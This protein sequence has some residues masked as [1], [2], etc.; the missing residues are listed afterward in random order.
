MVSDFAPAA[1]K[2]GALGSEAVIG[3]V[4]E[5]LQERPIERLVVDPVMVS[6]HGAPLLPDAA[7]RAVRDKVLEH[8]LLVTP[9]RH[10]AEALTGRSV[11]DPGSMKEA[12]QRIFDM[13]AK[14]V[15]IKGSHLDRIV[16]D[17][18]Y[19]GTGFVEFGADRVDS[20]RVHGSGCTFSAMIVARLAH[21]D[22]LLDAVAAAREFITGAIA[23]APKLG[24]GISPVHPMFG[25]WG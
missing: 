21:G 7:V 8:A 17:I 2:T 1:A 13:G 18:V 23:N 4:V 24:Q 25:S 6:K 11:G 14:N 10:E 5:L 19:D 3:T 22:D 16:R 20:R 9:N 15:L 12:A